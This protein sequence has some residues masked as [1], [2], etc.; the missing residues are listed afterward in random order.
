MYF[1]PNLNVQKPYQMVTF[2][3]TQKMGNAGGLQS[4]EWASGRALDERTFAWAWALGQTVGRK[5]GRS[6]PW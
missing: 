3:K 6:F 2:P 1:D 4:R 5:G